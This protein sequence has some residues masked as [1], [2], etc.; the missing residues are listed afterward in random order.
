MTKQDKKR[1]DV[2][3]ALEAH[4]AKLRVK[5]SIPADTAMFAKGG[6]RYNISGKGHGY[7]K[8]NGAKEGSDWVSK[9][10]KRPPVVCYG[11]GK[12]GHKKG[13]RS[14]VACYGCGK[15]GHKKKE[16]QSHHLWKENQSRQVTANAVGPPPG[17]TE[18]DDL[19][20]TITE[21]SEVDEVKVSIPQDQKE[22][23]WI[24]DS[25]ASM[26]VTRDISIFVKYQKFKP[27][28]RSVN[29]VDNC[30][31]SVTVIGGIAVAFS[32]KDRH[33]F[34]NVLHVMKFGRFCLLSLFK[35]LSDGYKVEF[36]LDTTHLLHRGTIIAS[37]PVTNGLFYLTATT[38]AVNLTPA[39]FAILH[40]DVIEIC[41][42][43]VGTTQE[44]RTRNT[45]LWKNAKPVRPGSP[46]LLFSHSVAADAVAAVAI[47][48][49]STPR[50]S[51]EKHFQQARLER[52]ANL[53]TR[54]LALCASAAYLYTLVF[55]L[56]SFE[57][58]RVATTLP[59]LPDLT[60]RHVCSH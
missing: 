51:G 35:L 14:P 13:K 40:N 49:I 58:R 20:L 55:K 23:T 19:I 43:E 2:Y 48:S 39:V 57:P 36:G 46:L 10:G 16:C 18:T 21:A 52:S 24:V 29:V 42:R 6:T 32:E 45:L 8:T 11:C 22:H 37:G 44:E 56:Q 53:Q 28:E 15:Q 41:Y 27:R 25:G 34:R 7:G 38:Q 59:T 5:H 1:E 26:H 17:G 9:N 47:T 3:I 54:R 33:I 4:E 31:V 30:Y 50:Q 60:K 12:Q